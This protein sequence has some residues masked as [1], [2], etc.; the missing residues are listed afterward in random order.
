MKWIWKLIEGQYDIKRIDQVELGWRIRYKL[1]KW[2]EH[3]WKNKRNSRDF[4]QFEDLYEED[5]RKRI[6]NWI[7][8]GL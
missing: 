3:N 7:W 8:K 4:N 1:E 6:K 5:R 2:K